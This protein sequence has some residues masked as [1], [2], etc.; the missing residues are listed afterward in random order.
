MTDTPLPVLTEPPPPSSRF[1]KVYT[2]SLLIILLIGGGWTAWISVFGSNVAHEPWWER[3]FWGGFAVISIGY[4]AILIL[5][6]LS[7]RMDASGISQRSY[8]HWKH[9]RWADAQAKREGVIIKIWS[10]KQVIVIGYALYPD[11]VALD[12][13]LRY[14]IPSYP[15]DPFITQADRE[16]HA[17]K[18]LRD[19]EKKCRENYP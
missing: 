9:I 14:Y 13:F 7:I 3:A 19:L 5:M 10:G 12:E 2:I 15:G 11:E 17:R 6:E 18:K 1:M 4:F 8:C 16:R